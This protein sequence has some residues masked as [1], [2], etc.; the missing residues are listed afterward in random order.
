MI[1]NKLMITSCAYLLPIGAVYADDFVLECER[2]TTPKVSDRYIL[3]ENEQ[4]VL[5]E[6][7]HGYW[8]EYNVR[9]WNNEVIIFDKLDLDGK[10][11]FTYLIDRVSGMSVQSVVTT[12]YDGPKS[13]NDYYKCEVSS[14]KF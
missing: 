7:L 5:K 8:V 13:G 4:T 10:A 6:G 2:I 11:L 9:S 12:S 1:L 14:K 3:N